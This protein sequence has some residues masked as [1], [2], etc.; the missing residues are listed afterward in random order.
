V[1]RVIFGPFFLH[2]R[3]RLFSAK[4]DD[5]T[6]VFTDHHH[7]RAMTVSRDVENTN[8]S[9]ASEKYIVRVPVLVSVILLVMQLLRCRT[10]R[11]NTTDSTTDSTSCSAWQFLP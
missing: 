9:G 7:K 10:V 8:G 11:P 3:N 5:T 1:A 4:K 2:D 6:Y